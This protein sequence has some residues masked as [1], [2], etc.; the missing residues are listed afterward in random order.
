[1]PGCFR[2]SPPYFGIGVAVEIGAFVEKA[3][4]FALTTM[5]NG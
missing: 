3:L 2:I 1:M 5:P 4:A